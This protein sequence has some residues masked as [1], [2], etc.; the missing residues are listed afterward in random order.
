M[1]VDKLNDYLHQYASSKIS[2]EDLVKAVIKENGGAGLSI[3]TSFHEISQILVAT[4]LYYL[5]PNHV[6]PTLEY[7]VS[8]GEIDIVQG[9]EIYDVKPMGSSAEQ[10]LK[11]YQQSDPNLIRGSWFTSIN[12]I[13]LI[14]MEGE[15]EPIT[16]IIFPDLYMQIIWGSPGKIYYTQYYYVDNNKTWKR[17]KVS[18]SN[19][20]FKVFDH[21]FVNT[22]G[23]SSGRG[24]GRFS[25]H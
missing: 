11:K 24:G 16:G 18:N 6:M 19:A 3:Y 5:D 12:D 14:D 8:S 9:N 22:G 4:K 13:K 23:S 1:K 2:T 15:T 10:Q 25:G 7:R 17:E 21:Y 20:F